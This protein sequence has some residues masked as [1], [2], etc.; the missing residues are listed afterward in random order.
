MPGITAPPRRTRLA[1]PFGAVYSQLSRYCATAAGRPT[2]GSAGNASPAGCASPACPAR[3]CVRAPDT[4]GR[5]DRAGR[6]DEGLATLAARGWANLPGPGRRQGRWGGWAVDTRDG[7]TWDPGPWGSK[8]AAR[9]QAGT[10]V[11]AERPAFAVMVRK[12]PA[13]RPLLGARRGP[14]PGPGSGAPPP[15]A[16]TSASLCPFV[17]RGRRDGPGRRLA[18]GPG[19]PTGGRNSRPNRASPPLAALHCLLRRD[20]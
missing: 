6:T 3:A 2:A 20:H 14:D 15:Q 10:T 18:P 12:L 13:Q 1:S 19:T 7:S 8:V 11:L 4:R 9:G 16:R 5:R 17:R